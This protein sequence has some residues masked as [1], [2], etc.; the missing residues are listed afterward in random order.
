MN[1]VLPILILLSPQM[2]LAETHHMSAF[3]CVETTGNES[4]D[5]ETAKAIAK[6]RLVL[7]LNCTVSSV[8]KYSSVK[9]ENAQSLNVSDQL[10]HTVISSGR[11][12]LQGVQATE[13]YYTEIN[14]I[15][16]YCVTLKI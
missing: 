8:E 5:R 2:C 6:G 15:K 7:D 3:A 9:T 16:N 12:R 11:L 14:G 1:K 10:T 13:S 4:V